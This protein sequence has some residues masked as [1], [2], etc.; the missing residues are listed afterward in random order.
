LRAVGGS[1]SP[2]TMVKDSPMAQITD[3]KAAS[4][5]PTR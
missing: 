4:I 2:K 3:G 1:A 5:S